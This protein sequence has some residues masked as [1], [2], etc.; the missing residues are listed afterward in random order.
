M[1]LFKKL[2]WGAAR[3]VKARALVELDTC[4]YSMI[5]LFIV[6]FFIHY[7]FFISIKIRFP[8][9]LYIFFILR[10][11]FCLAIYS[12]DIQY[13][14][15]L[16]VLLLHAY[17]VLGLCPVLRLFIENVFPIKI[18]SIIQCILLFRGDVL[19]FI[20]C[21]MWLLSHRLLLSFLQCSYINYWWLEEIVRWQAKATRSCISFICKME[22]FCSF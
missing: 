10:T 1:F 19:I 6:E 17:H 5:V 11:I 12:L 16:L 21:L 2:W 14:L 8:S 20:C 7:S 3:M 4:F 9:C 22:I 15:Y 13:R 18:Q